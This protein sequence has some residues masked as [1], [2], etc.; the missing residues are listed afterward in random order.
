MMSRPKKLGITAAVLWIVVFACGAF[1]IAGTIPSILFG[2]F[3]FTSLLGAIA[4]T[5]GGA[6][7]SEPQYQR[8]G[9][10]YNIEV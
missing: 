9:I 8:S 1:G 7:L 5:I 3:L 10:D 2:I 4:C 6:I